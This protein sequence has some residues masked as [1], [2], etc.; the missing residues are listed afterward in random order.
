M[1]RWF[2]TRI[3]PF[4]PAEIRQPPVKL[5]A[6]FWHFLRPVWWAFALLTSLTLVLAAIEVGILAY[7]GRIIDL[8]RVSAVPADFFAHALFE[9]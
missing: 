7:I 9:M 6:F 5:A 1:F 4:V 8:M 3:D 2:E